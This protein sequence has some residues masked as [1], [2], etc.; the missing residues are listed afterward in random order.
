MPR[1]RA[2][3][4]SLD[5]APKWISPED[6]AWDEDVVLAAYRS[7]TVKVSG[8]AVDL[9]PL[10]LYLTGQTRY[11]LDAPDLQE[12]LRTTG[13]L[14]L[15]QAEVWT[16]RVLPYAERSKASQHFRASYTARAAKHFGIAEK[17]LAASDE[18]A[19][20]HGVVGLQSPFEDAETKALC[21]VL[22]GVTQRDPPYRGR[23]ITAVSAYRVSAIAEVGAAVRTLS[24]DLLEVERRV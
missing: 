21:E 11:D 2:P 14:D 16:L 7:Q 18:H 22:D 4:H 8:E 19:F 5:H 23:L 17:E 12:V 20:V 24:D 9:T 13:C 3:Q 15:A 6:D 1:Y 10:R